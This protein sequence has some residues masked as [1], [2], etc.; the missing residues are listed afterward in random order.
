MASLSHA[1]GDDDPTL[2]GFY[3]LSGSNRDLV[4]AKRPDEGSPWSEDPSIAGLNTG[5]GERSPCLS[6][7][8]LEVYFGSDRASPTADVHDLFVA[9]RAGLGEPFASPRPIAE[10][11]TAS[12]EDDAWI[13]PD[14]RILYFSSDRS[15]NAEIYQ[16]RR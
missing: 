8:E 1:A 10:L 13:S 3:R 7:D 2:T 5:A 16:S 4:E 11:N 6:P 12:D 15:G 14:G 9:T